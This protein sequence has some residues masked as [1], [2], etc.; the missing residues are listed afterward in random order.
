MV[1]PFVSEEVLLDPEVRSDEVL[2]FERQLLGKVVGQDR[3]VRRIVN[4]YQIYMAGRGSPGRP[5]GKPLFFC[6]TGSGQTR[7]RQTSP[8]DLVGSPPTLFH[9]H[10]TGF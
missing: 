1:K 5:G 6:P 2:D 7:G 10:F 8:G 9:K 4:M 3:A